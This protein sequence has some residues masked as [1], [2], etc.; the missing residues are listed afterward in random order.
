MRFLDRYLNKIVRYYQTPTSS[1]APV[2]VKDLWIQ[3]L[4]LVP[5]VALVLLFAASY[6]K[7]WY[8][9][10]HPISPRLT[11]QQLFELLRSTQADEAEAPD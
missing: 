10:A 1:W 4:L 3:R 8:D 7:E 6:L 5:I 9:Q 2:R 11:D